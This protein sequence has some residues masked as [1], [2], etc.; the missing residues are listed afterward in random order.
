MSFEAITQALNL[1]EHV[2]GP[3]RMVAV[4]LADH[5]QPKPELDGAIC[6]W[7]S[8]DT[9]AKKAGVSE[10]TVHRA[11]RKLVEFGAVTVEQ[12]RDGFTNRT[13]LYVWH[14]WLMDEWDD[15]AM[16]ERENAARGYSRSQQSD[17]TE[18][19]QNTMPEPE[20]LPA[21]VTLETP[22]KATHSPLDGF[23]E[24]WT[25]Y[26]RKT[27]K[28][29]AQRA[30]KTALKDGATPTQLLDA[31]NAHIAAWKAENREAK[32]I[33]YPAT[34]LNGGHW[35]DQPAQTAPPA[36]TYLN[37]PVVRADQTTPA[38]TYDYDTLIARLEQGMRGLTN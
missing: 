32:Y 3:A 7:P 36:P 10:S 13:N 14:P 11:V 19:E 4:V 23:D 1:P 9:I 15:D 27:A 8:L 6:C 17:P 29:T 18:P 25:T 38:E 12:R 35:A 34:W 21:P 33:P 20:T 30:Y 31:L 26:P 2:T 24:W 22:K 28:K 16:I 5:M 37:T